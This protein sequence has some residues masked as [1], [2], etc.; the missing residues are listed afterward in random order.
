MRETRPRQELDMK[1]KPVILL[2]D[3]DAESLNPLSEALTRRYQGDYR[4]ISH[5][6]AKTAIEHLRGMQAGRE[7]VALV[8]A[9]LWM[10]EMTGIEMLD[11]AHEIYPSAQRALLVEWGDREAAP[12]I[13][14]GCAYGH[15]E[16]YLYRPWSPPEIYLYPA[17]GEFLTD[18]TRMHGPP[19]ELIRVIGN[20]PS[21][22]AHQIC[23]LLER[24][25]IPYGFYFA[26][27]NTGKQL[28]DAARLDDSRLPVVVLLDGHALVNP[29][30]SEVLDELGATKLEETVCDVAIVGG[31]PAGL[32]AAVYS[33]SEG[34]RTIVIEPEAVGG[35]AGTSS[36][37]R[38]YLGFPRG[39]SGAELARRA[40]EQ[41]WLFGTKYAFAREATGLT[42][43]G[44]H[45][46]V[47]LSDGTEI[48]AKAVIIATGAAYRRLGIERLDRFSGAGLFYVAPGNARLMKGKDVL[49]AGG[50]NSAGQ[51]VVHLAK[52][53]RKVTFLVRGDSLA[54]SMSDY[55]VQ[56]IGLQSNVD[57]RLCTTL[58][59]G[60]G[61]GVLE[62]VTILDQRTG[63]K[64]V[65]PAETL[66]VLI[67]ARPH[68]D[69]LA[70]ILQRDRNGFILTGSD[71]DLAEADLQTRQPGRFE[72]SMPGVF[73]VGDVRFGSVKRVA[74]AV[75]EGSVTVQYIHEYLSAPAYLSGSEAVSVIH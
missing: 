50:G 7:Q 43:D 75:G 20:E 63:R 25:G 58:V 69:W 73:A 59:D 3:D 56:E 22:R 48:Q 64:E 37:I 46:I 74:S 5:L 11:R 34:L 33:A 15:L 23:E 12:T 10:P 2:V 68:T 28:L 47:I 70:D 36:L 16:N 27:S 44:I 38:N 65:L 40:Y 4:V 72:T 24:S 67:G 55:L 35:Q 61:E 14:E 52:H 41:A 6:S 17:I 71:V 18:W 49:V 8:I 45:R 29:S 13:L 51:A 30:N 57:V 1:T 31:G 54:K 19:M 66:F 26:G 32:A 9:D 21:P 39:I 60:D 53:A 62:T 42:A